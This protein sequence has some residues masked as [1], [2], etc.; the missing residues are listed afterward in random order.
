MRLRWL[1]H[2]PFEG[3]GCIKEWAE[4][5]DA[6]ISC[7]RLYAGDPLPDTEIFDWLVVMGGPMG[8]YDHD[9]H[10]WLVAEKD[11]IRQ[12]I[13]AGKTV[14]GICLGAQ[15]IADVLGARVYPGPQKEIGWFPIQRAEGAPDLLPEALTVFHW[16]GDTF[17]T[18]DGAIHLAASES[19][20]NQ[21]FVYNGR[22]V[23]LQFHMETTVESMEALIE[24]CADELVDA[25]FIQT[26]EQMQTGSGNIGNINA[27]MKYLL[28]QL[29]AAPHSLQ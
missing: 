29:S 24:N 21:G 3:L 10:P 1:Q 2:V 13:R 19:C 12:S 4:A 16:H 9:E 6:E 7:T 22:V 23:A 28:D 20:Q 8:I 15:L 5:Q 18:P 11:F 14:L 25:P 26:A 27:A 17:D